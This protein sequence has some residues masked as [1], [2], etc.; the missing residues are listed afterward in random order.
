MGEFA[1]TAA[2]GYF[3]AIGAPTLV[4]EWCEQHVGW[5]KLGRDCT[6]ILRGALG[7]RLL[8]CFG[9]IAQ[10]VESTHAAQTTP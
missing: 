9:A 10:D 6:I 5:A 8:S 7:V 1:S 2:A 3:A 4:D